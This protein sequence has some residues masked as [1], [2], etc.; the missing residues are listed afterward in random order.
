MESGISPRYAPSSH[1]AICCRML[2]SRSF[3][4]VEV[5]TV[6]LFYVELWYAH[7]RGKALPCRGWLA[8]ATAYFWY[9]ANHLSLLEVETTLDTIVRKVLRAGRR[10]WTVADN[11]YY[12]L[13]LTVCCKVRFLVLTA[14]S[15][16]MFPG[17]LLL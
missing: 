14:A 15:V 4:P 8:L 16:K 1:V 11:L 7:C 2:P 9:T 17:V 3:S 5:S 10:V 12:H 6:C 13:S